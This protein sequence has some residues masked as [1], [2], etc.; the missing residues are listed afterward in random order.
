[1]ASLLF[2]TNPTNGQVYTG[3]NGVKY[4]YSTTSTSWETRV[5]NVST[6][7]GANPGSNPPSNPSAGTL[8]L[9]T[10]SKTL[11]VYI[12]SGSTGSWLA[13]NGGGGGSTSS[14]ASGLAL[15][16]SATYDG[17]IVIPDVGINLEVQ[18]AT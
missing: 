3:P 9:D 12:V 16:G 13:V 4:Q 5:T 10:D 7:D 11:Y 8:W 1:M 18:P 17:T 14:D 6:L 15:E 2:P